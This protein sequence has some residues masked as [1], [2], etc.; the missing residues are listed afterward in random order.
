M[1]DG[2]AARVAMVWQALGA[3]VGVMQPQGSRQQARPGAPQLAGVLCGASQI[4]HRIV[5]I[6]SRQLNHL[7][8]TFIDQPS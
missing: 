5:Q 4:A 6:S 1:R 8:H 2:G 3:A 7:R